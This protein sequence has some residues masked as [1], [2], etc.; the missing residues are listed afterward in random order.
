MPLNLQQVIRELRERLAAIDE[1]IA[2]LERLAAP[3]KPGRPRKYPK[4]SR[5][6]LTRGKE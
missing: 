1:I 6:K 2:Y 4:D 5:L 3:R